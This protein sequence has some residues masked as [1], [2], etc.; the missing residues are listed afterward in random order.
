MYIYNNIQYNNSYVIS[1]YFD[2]INSDVSDKFLN[3][4][5]KKAEENGV[6][7]SDNLRI[8]TMTALAYSSIYL[9]TNV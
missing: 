4:T 3:A 6:V 2:S 5:R 1:Y 9:I 8:N 7:D